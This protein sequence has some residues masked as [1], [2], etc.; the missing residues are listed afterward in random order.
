MNVSESKFRQI[1]REEARRVLR[2]ADVL[3]GPGA[4]PSPA[5]PGAPADVAVAG[6]KETA[7]RLKN[8]IEQNSDLN[9]ATKP[10]LVDAINELISSGRKSSVA[11]FVTAAGTVSSANDPEGKVK[12]GALLAAL[13]G[14]QS[15]GDGGMR[16]RADNDHIGF[17]NN[18]ESAN[19]LK[20]EIISANVGKMGTSIVDD[21]VSLAGLTPAPAAPAPVAGTRTGAGGPGAKSHTI[22]AGDSISK[23]AAANYNPS[24]PLSN[25]SMP[26]YTEIATATGIK[27]SDK[28]NIGGKLV[29][30]AT[31]SDG[32]YTLK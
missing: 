27:V 29:L 4:T 6:Q 16:I 30:P 32:K 24:V 1:L 11:A 31:L 7:K 8:A 12:L 19:K 28:L 2:E 25:A 18:P 20:N 14:K 17:G 5:T 9:R 21:L 13:M 15:T 23:I 3:T 10:K 22:V 26:I